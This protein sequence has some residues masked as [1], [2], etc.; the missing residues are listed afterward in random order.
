MSEFLSLIEKLKSLET[1]IKNDL[2]IKNESLI[3][4]NPNKSVI[5]FY[6]VRYFNL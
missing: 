4:N 6:S 3:N 5:I 2:L 1:S